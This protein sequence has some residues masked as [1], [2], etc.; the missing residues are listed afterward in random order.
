MPLNTNLKKYMIK[1]LYLLGNVTNESFAYELSNWLGQSDKTRLLVVEYFA[2]IDESQP[3]S[4]SVVNLGAQSRFDLRS[5]F[6][7]F[8]IVFRFKPDII[9][10]NHTTPGLWG[11]IVGKMS[12]A[13]VVRTIH[14][15]HTINNRW[16]NI[17][18]AI[19]F[20][21]TDTVVCNSYNTLRDIRVIEKKFVKDRKV[22]Y[23]GV[24]TEMIKKICDA[25]RGTRSTNRS[26]DTF[27]VGTV[28]RLIAVKNY[29]R[30]IKAWS[31]HVQ[32]FENSQLVIIGDG[33]E[34]VSLR[35]LVRDYNLS[36]SVLLTGRLGREEVYQWL[37]H[38]DL[39]VVS[40]LSEGFCNA[41]VEAMCAG[42]SIAYA[43]IPVLREVVGDSGFAFNPLST[44]S[45]ADAI[46]TLASKEPV[47]TDESAKR[48]S[49]EC[50]QKYSIRAT[51]VKYVDTYAET[52]MPNI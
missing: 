5:V 37:A 27:V 49:L 2:P 29:G 31:Y 41:V 30:L 19:S 35:S 24:D 8:K 39:F 45:I 17:A 16:Q 51:A 48:V 15:S 11:S 1:V 36:D 38:L 44:R 50:L 14:R 28:G 7:L 9:H 42:C 33:P 23:N 47:I 32:R 10:L 18:N 26:K 25:A 3:R 46:S 40:S 20:L 12:G 43:D 13:K 21:N 52:L 6:R 22:I 34:S 4:S